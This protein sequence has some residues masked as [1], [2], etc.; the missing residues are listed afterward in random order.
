VPAHASSATGLWVGVAARAA[1][2]VYDPHLVGSAGPPRHLAELA[3]PRFVS[4]LGFAPTETDFQPLVAAMI[5]S[6]GIRRTEAWLEALREHATV[7]P[8]NEAVTQQI[9]AGQSALGPIDQ[10][11]WFRLHA[12]LPHETGAALSYFAPGDPG[13][14]V[15]ISGAAILH[16]SHQQ[17]KAQRFLAFLVGEEAQKIIAAGDS[18]EYPL[19]PGVAPSP[20]LPPLASLKAAAIAPAALGDGSAVLALEQRLGL[21]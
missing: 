1:A 5:R 21:L 2:I 12:S 6:Y 19:R 3:A 14:L 7:Y 8:D 16:S 15:D 13:D 9:D 4:R 11:Y 18:F 20:K 10:Y 17:A